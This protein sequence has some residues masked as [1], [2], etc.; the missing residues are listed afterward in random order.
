MFD[1][2]QKPQKKAS[3]GFLVLSDC[4]QHQAQEGAPESWDRNQLTWMKNDIHGY[5]P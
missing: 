1:D 3:A 2:L 4:L 5:K